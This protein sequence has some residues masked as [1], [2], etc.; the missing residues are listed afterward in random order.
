MLLHI[1][2]SQHLWFADGHWHDFI[3]V[4]DDATSATY[5]AQLVEQE[6]TL[7]A[8]RALRQVVEAQGLFCS[9]YSD[10]ASHFWP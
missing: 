10:R 6:S 3:A 5:Y 8:L 2:A 1:D 9:L 4:L 7:T